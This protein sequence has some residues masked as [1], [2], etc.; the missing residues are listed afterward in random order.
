MR[1]H[2]HVCVLGMLCSRIRCNSV[3]IR[4]SSLWVQCLC[5]IWAHRGWRP[6]E[7]ACWR[8][9]TFAMTNVFLLVTHYLLVRRYLKIAIAWHCNLQLW[10]DAFQLQ[11]SFQHVWSIEELCWF[12]SSTKV[13]WSLRDCEISP[14][15]DSM[16]SAVSRESSKTWV[17]QSHERDRSDLHSC[18]QYTYAGDAN[19]QLLEFW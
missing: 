7:K 15:S 12:Q 18:I 19:T 3:E 14:D 1:T 17:G 4:T 2:W 6:S 9:A 13:S 8:W 11:D 16:H 5:A 10:G